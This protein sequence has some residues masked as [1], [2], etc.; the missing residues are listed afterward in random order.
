[1]LLQEMAAVMMN[2]P[3]DHKT[4]NDHL[5]VLIQKSVHPPSLFVTGHGRVEL[6]RWMAFTS[7][8]ITLYDR[9]HDML[10]RF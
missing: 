9:A 2:T 7:I 10:C 4:R 8:Y 1:M 6:T 3:S 5:A